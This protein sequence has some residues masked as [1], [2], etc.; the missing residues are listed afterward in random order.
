MQGTFTTLVTPV[1][2]TGVHSRQGALLKHH[3][4][5]RKISGMD[6]CDEHRN[7]EE[8]AGL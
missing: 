6:S 3:A 2:V 8:G 1:L 4:L 5:N 7:D